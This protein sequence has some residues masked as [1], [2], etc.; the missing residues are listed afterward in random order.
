VS[1]SAAST[2]AGVG[3]LV[4]AMIGEKRVDV[5]SLVDRAKERKNDG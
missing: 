5:S 3:A 2:G 4:G 1:R